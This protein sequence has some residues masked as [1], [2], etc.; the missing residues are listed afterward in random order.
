MLAFT[1]LL[2]ESLH[3]SPP[4]PFMMQLFPDNFNKFEQTPTPSS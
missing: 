1:C 3:P 2:P 4:P